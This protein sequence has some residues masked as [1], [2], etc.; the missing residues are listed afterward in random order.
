MLLTIDI[1]N[2]NVVLGAY[3]ARGLP[4][5]ASDDAGR[6]EDAPLAV[7]RLPTDRRG[8]LESVRRSLESLWEKSG[9]TASD[10]D[11]AAL[12]S[13]VEPLTEQWRLLLT[14]ML[15]RRPLVLDQRSELGMP[16][17]VRRPE[18]VGM[19]RLANAVAVRG[20]VAGAAA[21]VD[22][23]TATTFNVVDSRGRFRGGAIAPGLGALSTSLARHAPALP[24]VELTPP[25][26]AIG[27]DTEEALRSGIVLGHAALVDG[28]IA[29]MR[30]ELDA[31]MRV[32]AT[33]GLGRIIAPLTNSIER[34]DPWLTLAGIREI[35]HL[36]AGNHARI[37]SAAR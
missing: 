3:P 11:D 27:G 7:W 16:L 5:C 22:F 4:P 1:G 24:T 31:P 20:R 18:R 6:E 26:S 33:G 36:N 34:Y 9:F 21:A 19:D 2:S 8:S 25:A 12:C 23:G 17:Q 29:R 28:L 13:V 35:Y 37:A 10:F 30:D 32:I 14:A 15:H